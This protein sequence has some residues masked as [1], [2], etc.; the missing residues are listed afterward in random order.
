[1]LFECILDVNLRPGPEKG[2]NGT[3][4]KSETGRPEGNAHLLPLKTIIRMV[5]A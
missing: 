4:G 5:V 3:Y 2:L 1:M